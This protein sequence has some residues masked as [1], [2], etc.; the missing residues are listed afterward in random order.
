[1]RLSRLPI[2]GCTA[3]LAAAIACGSGSSSPGPA[4][5][6]GTEAAPPNDATSEA[7]F[8]FCGSSSSGSG[9]SSGSGSSSGSADAAPD[10]QSCDGLKA[11]ATAL[12]P[13]AKACNPALASQCTAS[14]DGICC[15]VTVSAGNESAVNDFA[16]A[17]ATYKAQCTPSC[18]GIV[19]KPA[20]SQI[21]QAT[22][23]GQGECQ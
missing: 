9:G 16:V 15:P 7:C 6:A 14:T 17:V 1:M 2:A 10:A 4:G 8:P 23:G 5:D 20:P 19:C 11:T 18:I 22:S 13:A 3:A 12:Q 21:C